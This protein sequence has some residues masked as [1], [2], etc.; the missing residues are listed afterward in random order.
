[1]SHF[2]QRCFLIRHGETEWSLYG[3]HTGRTDLPMLPVGEGQARALRPALAAE[4]FSVVLASPLHRA[5]ETCEL[6]G[7]RPESVVEPD[8]LEWDYGSYEGRTT[9]DIWKDRPGW[10]LFDDGA[11]GGESVA[12]VGERVDRVIA[13]VRRAEPGDVACVAHAHVLRVL[14]ARW[15]GLDP[16]AGRYFVLGPASISVLGWER[17]Q[18]A[19]LQW[20]R[21]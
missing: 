19:V 21:C 18:P 2:R 3:R 6:A 10:N 14:A 7:L 11:P 20:N 13:R 4:S 8:L 5:R 17:A 1:M 15:L 9:V 16:A 12:E